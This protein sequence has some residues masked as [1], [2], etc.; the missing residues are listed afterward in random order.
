[1]IMQ[2][3]SFGA[4]HSA[5][6]SLPPMQPSDG[7]AIAVP[8]MP[9]QKVVTGDVEVDAVLWLREVISTG[10]ADLI[11]KA[12]LAA[13]KIKTPLKD[14]EQRYTSHLA[15]TKPGNFAAVMASIGFADLDALSLTAIQQDKRRREA[16]TRFGDAI[17]DDTPAEQFCDQAL[18]GLERVTQWNEFDA[19]QVDERFDALQEQRPGT[20]MDCVCELTYWNELYWLRDAVNRDCG[21][22]TS[23]QA[24]ARQ[25]YVFRLLSRIPPCNPDEAA[26]V[27][28][29]LTSNDGMDRGHTGAIILNLIGA[30]E[31][32]HPYKGEHDE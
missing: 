4:S 8:A 31:P 12:A 14:L 18:A 21:G 20:L 15:R 24:N 16:Q 7:T 17:F 22:Y 28:R 30:P 6:F 32:Y 9:V 19:A 27:F 11:E 23:T 25:D 13:K 1:M 3:K 26:D 5:L 29:Y 10:Q 2:T